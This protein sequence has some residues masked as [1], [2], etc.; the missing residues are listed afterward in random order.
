VSD[1]R[2]LLLCGGWEGHQPEAVADWAHDRLLRDGGVEVTRT[3]DLDVLASS[4]L[5]Q[6]DLLLT[7]WT[8]GALTP[9]QEQGFERAVRD[10]LGLVSWHGGASAFLDSR[11]YRF[12]L[13][14]EFVDHPGGERTTFTVEFDPTHPLGADLEPVELTTEQYYLLVDPAVDV[15]ATTTMVGSTERPWTAGVRMPVAW[16]RRWGAGRVFYCSLGHDVAELE[17]PPVLS[18][19]RRAVASSARSRLA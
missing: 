15:V 18:L 8:W 5:T 6:H 9:P 1:R 16:T 10:G 2:V 3:T 12:V 4:E 17:R 11:V 19:L 13:G 7:V 14:G